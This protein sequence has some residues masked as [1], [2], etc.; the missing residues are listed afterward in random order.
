MLFRSLVK[1]DDLPV[2]ENIFHLEYEDNERVFPS[3]LHGEYAVKN[4]MEFVRN[5][6]GGET[7]TRVYANGEKFCDE[8]GN[9]F[10]IDFHWDYITPFGPSSKQISEMWERR[11]EIEINGVKASVLSPDDMLLHLCLHLNN[12]INK[13]HQKLIW[14]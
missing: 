6:G 5:F 13:R 12:H 4:D 11:K 2:V 14:W 3:Q 10:V 9:S 8:G 7:H 1:K